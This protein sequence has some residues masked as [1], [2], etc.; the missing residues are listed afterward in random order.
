MARMLEIRQCRSAIKRE[1]SQKLTLEALGIK[2]LHRK[3]IHE[4][5]PSIRGMIR[6][7]SH[8]VEVWEIEEP[9]AEGARPSAVRAT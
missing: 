6:K 7:I 8:L 2:R 4:D 1:K 5:T 9:E 3:V